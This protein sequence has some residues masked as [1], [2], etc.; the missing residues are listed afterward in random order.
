VSSKKFCNKIWNLFKFAHERFSSLNHVILL[1]KTI[2]ASSISTHAKHLSLVD[3]YILSRLADTVMCT[4]NGFQKLELHV[5]T[6]VLRNFI[7]GDLC[8][9][10]LEFVKPVLYGGREDIDKEVLV[11]L[12]FRGC[13]INDL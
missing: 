12:L 4:Q 1:H 9:V 5:V 13:I 7:I 8:G 2:S 10:Y 3:K 6:D 11:Y